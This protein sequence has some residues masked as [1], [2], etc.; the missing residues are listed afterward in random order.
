MLDWLRC[1][2]DEMAGELLG[3]SRTLVWSWR[4]DAMCFDAKTADRYAARVGVHPSEVWSTWWAEAM[5]P[6]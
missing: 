4:R 5:A 1:E 3:V 2:T 6:L